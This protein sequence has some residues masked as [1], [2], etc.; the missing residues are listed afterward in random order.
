MSEHDIHKEVKKRYGSSLKDGKAH[1]EAHESL[2]RRSF[3]RNTGLTAMGSLLA[4]QGNSINQMMPNLLTRSLASADTDRVL[5]LIRFNGG[6]DGLNTIIHRG[7]DEYYNI[8]P[9]LA[10]QEN[11]LWGLSNEYGMP[12]TTLGLQP[13]WDGGRMKVIHN[14]GYPQPNYSHFRSS[15]IWASASDS[16]EVLD[17]GWIGRTMETLFPSY[18]DTPPTV[19]PAMQIGIESNL[20]FQGEESNLALSVKNPTEFYRIAQQGQLHNLVGLDDCPTD[21]EL[22]FV[23]QTANSAFRYSESIQ[24]AY[25]KG[26]TK[27][28]YENNGL[29]EQLSIVARLIKGELGTK[30]YMVT[31]GGFDNHSDQADRHPVL[32]S[33]IGNAV[34][35]FYQ[36]LDADGFGQRVLGM[37]FSEF[38]RTIFENGS[39]GTDHGTGTPMILFGGDDLGNG[40]VGNAPD[41]I[42]T[43][44]YGDPDYD[45]DFRSVY[46]S[47]LKD[48]L[49]IDE[50][51]VE[52]VL[53]DKS[54]IDNLVPQANIPVGFN[55]DDVLLGYRTVKGTN[56]IEIKYSI[57]LGGITRLSLAERSGRS[58]RVLFEDF[59]ERGSHTFVFDPQKELV[60]PGQY[61]LRCESGGKV[62]N[63]NMM[64][65]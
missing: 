49:G 42:N 18:L 10:I 1:T 4:L 48:W 8:R 61:K 9:T 17:T 57:T 54:T 36:D 3:L 43:G 46:G 29:A 60:Q 20:I 12:N 7:N 39:F 32:M 53:G 33:R 45:I 16:N 30:V 21:S 24:N 50:R 55:A 63:R 11:N 35:A 37:T 15:D 6:N 22:R 5:V 58:K 13:L 52:H 47:V 59:A 26:I 14:V 23:R 65:R 2:S 19:P 25:K 38:G 51:V 31:I 44:Q 41:L 40:F 64:V 27:A 56:I 34:A 62:Y 28:E